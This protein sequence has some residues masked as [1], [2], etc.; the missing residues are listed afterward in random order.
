MNSQTSPDHVMAKLTALES[1]L[2][3][4]AER[5][6]STNSQSSPDQ[7]MAKLS[8]L[9]NRMKSSDRPDVSPEHVMAKL[10]ALESR[11]ATPM[12]S[13]S[14]PSEVMRKLDAMH[15][16]LDVPDFT[17]TDMG[18]IKDSVYAKL[19]ELERRMAPSMPTNVTSEMYT[20]EMKRL[21]KLKNMRAKIVNM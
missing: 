18:S 7:V 12:D 3:E 11:L 13:Q 2:S 9:E 6:Q 10:T 8:A 1:R 19:T 21:G 16:R 20:A 15:S 17:S 4:S 5:F 14:H